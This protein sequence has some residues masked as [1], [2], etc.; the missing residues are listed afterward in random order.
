M[1]IIIYLALFGVYL[2]LLV[3]FAMWTQ[4][5]NLQWLFSLVFAVWCT[6]WF[7]VACISGDQFDMA[8]NA[9]LGSYWWREF[10][11]RK[12]PRM[13]DRVKKLV[14]A[15]AKALK[16]KVVAAMPKPSPVGK[17]ALVPVGA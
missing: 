5:R 12:P 13:R 2:V 1:S 4:A 10:W 9:L 15:K 7:V 8:F 16:A 11:K 17:P 14:G 6:A 3:R